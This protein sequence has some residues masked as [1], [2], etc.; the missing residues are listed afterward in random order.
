MIGETKAK[1]IARTCN[2]LKAEKQNYTSL[3]DKLGRFFCPDIDVMSTSASGSEVLRAITSTG[4][5]ASQRLKSGLYSNTMAM[6]KGNI[7][8]P[9][10]NVMEIPIASEWYAELSHVTQHHIMQSGF[11]RKFQQWMEE[12]VDFGG[13]VMYPFW[14]SVTKLHEFHIFPENSCFYTHNANGRI[15]S[16]YRE[17]AY[18]AEQ[19]VDKFGL[20]AVSDKIRKAYAEYDNG[21]KFKFI[22]CMR[23]NRDR[24]ETRLDSANLK[25]SSIYV[26]TDGEPEIVKES[27]SSQFRYVSAHFYQKAGEDN[28]RSP[29]MQALQAMETLTRVV[30]S[31]LNANELGILPPTFFSDKNA[32][33]TATLEAGEVGYYDASKGAPWVYQ[34]DTNALRMN[35][36]LI[37][38]LEAEIDKLFFVDLFAMLEQ[39]KGGVKTAYEVSQL[40]AERTQAIAPIANSLS[41]YFNDIYTIVA[42][43][44]FDSG[45]IEP[46]PAEVL[47]E[48][49]ELKLDVTYMSRLDVRLKEIENVSMLEAV[50][51]AVQ[52]SAA[53]QE[54]PLIGAATKPLQGIIN[55][56]KSHD[57]DP[58]TLNTLDEAQEILSAQEQAA[59][60]QQQS[61]M[62]Q[63]S[64][65]PLDLQA[66][67][68][69]GSPMDGMIDEGAGGMIGL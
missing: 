40:V 15:S 7:G 41:G 26:A 16:M 22:H 63:Q 65:K 38:G 13:S 10:K 62:A 57:V 53:V 29:A 12:Y 51:Q 54:S 48:N 23:E 5:V 50:N 42:T 2:E 58:A 39:A 55:I 3:C 31:F 33:E 30:D 59:A 37:K 35:W 8:S 52:Y 67:V 45:Q 20:D 1:Q 47:G 27:G 19:A 44:L 68:Q 21:K 6:G 46:A 66:P 11:A 43:D 18:T 25:Y 17:F 32:A 56:F 28:G 61:E 69:A 24:D 4:E 14:D 36:E 49:G 60:E 34:I 9:D 64:V